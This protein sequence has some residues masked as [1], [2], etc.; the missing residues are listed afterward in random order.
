M[1]KQTGTFKRALG[2]FGMAVAGGLLALGVHDR[3]SPSPDAVTSST[4]NVPAHFV[5]M[6]TAGG[7]VVEAADFTTAATKS[8]DAVVHVTT[9]ATVQRGPVGSYFWGYAQPAPEQVRGAGSGVIISND[10]YIV[11]N[12]HVVENADKIQVHLNDKRKYD[13]TVIGRDPSTDIALIKID[14]KDLPTL[15]FGNSDD[16]KVGQWVLAVGNPMNLTSTVTAGIVSAKA[17]SINIL[18]YDPAKDIFPIES[19]IQTDAAVNP[20]NSGGALVNTTGDLIGIN[21]AIASTTGAYTGYSFAV[22]SNIVSKVTG[23]LM[24]FGSVR[25]AYLGVTISD[26]D[27]DMAKSLDLTRLKG[28]YV[29]DVMDDGAAKS[30][31]VK[32]G[33]VIVKVGAMNVDNVPE[34]QEQV[35]K[36]SPGD[37]VAIT[38]V[39]DGKEEVMD[40]TLLGRAGA[41]SPTASKDVSLPTLGAELAAATDAELKALRI[42]NG[43][44]VVRINGGKLRSIGIREGFIITKIDQK[45]MRSPAD[46]DKALVGRQGGVLIE[47][48]YPNGMRAY[49]GLG[50]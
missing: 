6:P 20:G 38:L 8:I 24:E 42:G 5:G 10:G 43:V 31:G 33:D 22:P 25:R 4:T 35:G 18:Q 44:K 3:I 28:V 27:Q 41:E 49:Y 26:I 15:T 47:G 7:T 16:V 45:P 2:Y 29:K 14:E 40:M 46:I 39:R 21:S 1:N 48:V 11:T 9:E 34:L 13:A 30:A 36:F 23:D 12:N 37:K 17:R 50:V 19:F 32:S